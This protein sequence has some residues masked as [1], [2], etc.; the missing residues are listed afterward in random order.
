MTHIN[1]EQK[2][3]KIEQNASIIAQSFVQVYK[4][5]KQISH[6]SETFCTKRETPLT[7]DLAW[8]VHHAT[9]SKLLISN[10]R[11]LHCAI[12]YNKV[13]EIENA[14]SDHVKENIIKNGYYLPDSMTVFGLLLTTSIF[15][16]T[17]QVER[18]R[19]MV[20]VLQC[21]KMNL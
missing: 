8:T 15:W 12:T 7:A 5:D 9:R 20:P 3:D 13:L 4:S 17:L 10:L 6:Q 18:I 1:D 16:K 19:C 2:N 14:I 21:I 11:T